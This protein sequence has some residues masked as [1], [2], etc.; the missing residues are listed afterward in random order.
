MKAFNINSNVLVKM[1][2]KGFEIWKK[3]YDDILPIDQQH[4][5]SYYYKQVRDDGLFSFQLWDFIRIFGPHVEMGFDTPIET[6]IF[7]NDTDLRQA[8]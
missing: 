7:F 1:K 6:T 5:L 4:P 3:H 2:P 8:P